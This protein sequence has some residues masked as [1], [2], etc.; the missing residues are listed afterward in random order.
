MFHLE[1]VAFLGVGVRACASGRLRKMWLARHQCTGAFF[2]SLTSLCRLRRALGPR[3]SQRTKSSHP[4][5]K[6]VLLRLAC[7]RQDSFLPTAV[8]SDLAAASGRQWLKRAF[9]AARAPVGLVNLHS[10]TYAVP[11]RESS[12]AGV[13]DDVV[14]DFGMFSGILQGCPLVG[15]GFVVLFSASLALLCQSLASVDKLHMYAVLLSSLTM[16]SGLRLHYSN[17]AL[18]PLRKRFSVHTVELMPLRRL[19]ICHKHRIR[20][21]PGMPTRARRQF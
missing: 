6:W 7:P 17:R 14:I 10:L 19:G 1:H 8:A 20:G 9:R 5:G 2:C 12:N 4:V 18:V 16:L 21:D 3:K 15:Q 11:E 13:D